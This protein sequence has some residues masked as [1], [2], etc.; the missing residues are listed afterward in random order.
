M[1]VVIVN[2]YIEKYDSSRLIIESLVGIGEEVEIVTLYLNEDNLEIPL[3]LARIHSTALSKIFKNAHSLFKWPIFTTQVAKKLKLPKADFYIVLSQ[4]FAH[5]VKVPDNSLIYIYDRPYRTN[6]FFQKGLDQKYFKSIQELSGRVFFSTH[7]LAQELGYE[8][9]Y[10]ILTRPFASQDFKTIDNYKNHQKFVLNIDD[11]SESFHELVKV[12]G[13]D[14]ELVVITNKKCEK[15]LKKQ[16]PFLDI[17]TGVNNYELFVELIKA[18]IY[19]D[20]RA[21]FPERVF[22]SL[23]TGVPAIVL[24]SRLNREVFGDGAVK[25]VSSM[26]SL[27][28]DFE[29]L[30]QNTIDGETL[31]R[32]SLRYNERVFKNKI[33]NVLRK[34]KND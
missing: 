5:Q 27:V 14:R 8:K 4:G 18:H 15:K 21:V 24:D 32:F 23:A 6:S 7:T 9:D 10:E 3:S 16:Y 28:S 13:P 30:T 25:F 29:S 1:K 12:L 26:S 31:R 2:D 20:L 11:F 33:L 22:C 19:I 17:Y 34:L